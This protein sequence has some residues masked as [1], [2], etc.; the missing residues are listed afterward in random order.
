MRP[1]PLI[2]SHLAHDIHA[3][4]VCWGLR[5]LGAEPRWIRSWA[6]PALPGLSLAIGPGADRAGGVAGADAVWFRRPRLPDRFEGAIDG[7]LPFLRNEWAR[8]SGNLHA[9][10]GLAGE[11]MWVNPP[12]A[13]AR[14]ERKLVQLRAAQRVGLRFPETLMSCDPAEIRRFVGRHGRVVYKPFQSHT[15]M[16]GSGR[17]FSS[18]ARLVDAGAL[19]EDDGLR[20]CPG[21]FQ[22]AIDKRHDVRVTMIGARAFALRLDAPAR[23]GVVDWRAGSLA[24]EVEAAP[25]VLPDDCVERL[26]ALMREL[27][28]VFGCIDLVAGADGELHFLEINQAGQFL[29]AEHLAPSLPLLGAM[30]AM[31]AQARPDYALE[32]AAAIRYA[33]YLDSDEHRSWWREVAPDIRDGDGV[34]P[35]VSV[36]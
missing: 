23:D 9:L 12:E 5:R 32:A 11:A 20:Q 7:D 33:D 26:H 4:A 25:L 8:F 2:V 30:C 36:E 16:D 14:A 29:F 1:R 6:D 35:G 3:A 21:I 34:P 28:I 10:P 19:G 24:G 17:M 15:W 22:Q 13:A 27:D 31:L 18:Y